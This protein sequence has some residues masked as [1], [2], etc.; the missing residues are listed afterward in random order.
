MML[1]VAL[2][3][4]EK[5]VPP[6]E[7]RSAT[8]TEQRATFV[9]RVWRV[10]QSTSVAPGQLYA[11][12]S[13]GTLVIASPTGKPSFGTWS[14]Q[15][16]ILTIVEDSLPYKVDILGLSETEFRIRINGPGEPVTITFELADQPLAPN[17]S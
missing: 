1:L 16:E 3:G 5:A 12:L 11:F 17:G 15:G 10:S 13:E 9:N 6:P 4:C 8:P 14:S 7:R 2:L